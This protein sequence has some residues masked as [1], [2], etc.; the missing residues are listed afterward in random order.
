E[1]DI[2]GYRYEYDEGI[3]TEVEDVSEGRAVSGVSATSY[4]DSVYLGYIENG[5]GDVGHA[6]Y[7][8]SHMGGQWQP[9]EPVAGQTAADPPQIAILNGRIH[10][11]F[12]GNTAK[13]ELR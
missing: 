12:N 9:Q 1:R 3:W 7:I 4:G 10:C 11:I 5:P 13:R 8:V 2:V 6:V